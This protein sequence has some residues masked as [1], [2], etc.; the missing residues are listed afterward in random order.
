MDKN[1]HS[2]VGDNL[3][4]HQIGG[5]VESFSANFCCRFCRANKEDLQQGLVGTAHS[6]QSHDLHVAY[7]TETPALASAYG[8]KKASVFSTIEN[9]HVTKGLPSDLAHDLF[10]GVLKEFLSLMLK[11]FQNREYFTMHQLNR[12][13][14]SFKFQGSDAN[15]KPS[16]IGPE[17][18]LTMC[19]MWVFFRLLPLFIGQYVP[20]DDQT[21]SV[22][23]MLRNIVD[24]LLSPSITTDQI[25]TLKGMIENFVAMRLTLWPDVPLKP[26]THFMLHYCTQISQFGPLSHL[27]TLRFEAKHQQLL[28]L[29]KPIKCTKNVCKTLATQHQFR[30]ALS[31][32]NRVL[33]TNTVELKKQ[34]NSTAERSRPKSKRHFGQ[35]DG[36][37][38]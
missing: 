30:T 35:S 6:V 31:S 12:H 3:A 8:V 17:I 15:N 33:L 13:I 1:V 4:S 18:K 2:S 34:K 23:L 24:Y 25:D 22:Y 7:V 14:S 9:F 11:D 36:Q 32:S 38:E 10:E 28:E 27:W 26:K 19:K 37:S 16:Q 29:F 21:W 20:E 5:L